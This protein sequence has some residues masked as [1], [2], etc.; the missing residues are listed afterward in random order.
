MLGH[1]ITF[2]LGTFSEVQ[3]ITFHFCALLCGWFLC[4]D[5]ECQSHVADF[6]AVT[7]DVNWQGQKTFLEMSFGFVVP[8][9][10]FLCAKVLCSEIWYLAFFKTWLLYMCGWD[11]IFELF[12]K[13]KYWWL[14][15]VF[16]GFFSSHFCNWQPEIPLPR[17]V[18]VSSVVRLHCSYPAQD[19]ET[20]IGSDNP[21]S[22][23]F[24]PPLSLAAFPL[25][26]S[27]AHPLSLTRCF[28]WRP[29]TANKTFT[30]PVVV[31]ICGDDETYLQI[32]P[33]GTEA[34]NGIFSISFTSE[35]PC[36]SSDEMILWLR[37]TQ[38]FMSFPQVFLLRNVVS[39][40]LSIYFP[41]KVWIIR[42]FRF[43]I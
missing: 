39:V 9:Q 16:L 13:L 3:L 30:L 42:M 34:G 29:G 2:S 14:L 15:L 28:P 32:L 18:S 6:R 38:G 10:R 21:H 24:T 26:R 33:A 4:G 31:W 35:S 8:V 36:A 41:L 5:S 37:S 20:K 11:L 7:I 40:N 27:R 22:W 1:I 19:L 43:F 23:L 17:P 12:W 25:H